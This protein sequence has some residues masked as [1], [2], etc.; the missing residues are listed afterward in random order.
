MWYFASDEYMPPETREKLT[1]FLQGSAICTDTDYVP[2]P[3]CQCGNETLW[4]SNRCATSVE[5]NETLT[6]TLRNQCNAAVWEIAAVNYTSLV[7]IYLAV[8]FMSFYLRWEEV[9]YD[10]NAQTAQDYSIE[11]ANPP[12]DAHDPEEWR[13]YFRE[14]FDGAEVAVCTCELD[15]DL[16]IQTLVKRRE[17]YRI[18]Q[19]LLDPGT[20][21]DVINIGHIAAEEE[22]HRNVFSKF[23]A[24]LMPGVPELLATLVVLNAKIQAL[25]QLTYHTTKVFVSFET[26]R[27]QRHVLTKITVGSVRVKRNDHT[28]LSDPKYL[29]R[30]KHMLNVAEA[31]EPNTIH[32]ESLNVKS[33]RKFREQSLTNMITF[34]GVAAC[35]VIVK[36]M[37][38]VSPIFAALTISAFNGGFPEVARVIVKLES[39]ATEGSKQASMFFKIAVFRWV[40]TAIVITLITPFTSTLAVDHGLIPQVYAIFVSEIITLNAYQ[41]IDPIGHAK[42]HL[43]APRAKNQDAMNLFFEGEEVEL[44]ER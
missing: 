1:Y 16:L 37:N 27:D 11:I 35:A 12:I 17:T 44:A 24:L 34:A 20:S 15:N 10:E 7:C 30:S 5:G 38:E 26:E 9:K 36:V 19:S 25:S 23:L 8:I 6:F 22:R 31:D 33:K 42:R 43:L 28:A 2:C 14:Q 4:E 13:E 41:L 3:E 40:N 32:W 21:M 18:I 29:F 39:H